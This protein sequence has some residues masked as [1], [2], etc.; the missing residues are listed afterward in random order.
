MT[1]IRVLSYSLLTISFIFLFASLV[2]FIL[3]WKVF[4]KNDISILHFS[5]TLV[6]FLA[7]AC[8]M[9][10]IDTASRTYWLC[11]GV[12]FLLHFLWTNVFMVSL[13][14]AIQVLYNAW[15]IGLHARRKISFYL[16]LISGAISFIWA[17]IW[18]IYSR[19]EGGYLQGESKLANETK[20]ENL[21]RSCFLSMTDNIIWAFFAPVLLLIGIKLAILLLTMIKLRSCK[22]ARK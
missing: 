15:L 7:L 5:H 21:E 9:F 17:L 13:C 22:C 6:L 12:A 1:L 11:T 19:F 20:L 14:I 8:L 4:F 3:A 2:I 18:L 10:G 16:V